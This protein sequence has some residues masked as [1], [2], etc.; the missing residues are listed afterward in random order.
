MCKRVAHFMLLKSAADN[1]PVNNHQS[2]PPDWWLAGT[3]SLNSSQLALTVSHMFS[4]DGSLLPC[5]WIRTGTALYIIG[6]G[7]L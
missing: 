4:T 2:N 3:F 6:L 7:Y 5:D 1:P